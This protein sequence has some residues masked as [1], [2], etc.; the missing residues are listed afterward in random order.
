M[1]C[2]TSAVAVTIDKC[3]HSRL[4]LLF[5]DTGHALCSLQLLCC[6]CSRFLVQS[7]HPKKQ[8]C[9][10]GQL[11]CLKEVMVLLL[12]LHAAEHHMT[13]GMQ[14]VVVCTLNSHCRPGS[15][16][17]QQLLKRSGCL[18]VCLQQP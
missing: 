13:V 4:W 5:H 11:A 1:L 18:P 10:P 16:A 12:H 7:R 8:A 9:A 2:Q 14:K 15:Q 17:E 3:C 6:F